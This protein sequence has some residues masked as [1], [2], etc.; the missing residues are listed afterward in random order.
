MANVLRPDSFVLSTPRAEI[1]TGIS[2]VHA[3]EWGRE[4]GAVYSERQ[5]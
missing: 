5:R 2:Q 1:G 4:G 3:D